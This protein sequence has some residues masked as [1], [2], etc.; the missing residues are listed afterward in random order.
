MH[1]FTYFIA[2]LSIIGAW[3]L[4]ISLTSS[5]FV[6]AVI[7]IVTMGFLIALLMDYE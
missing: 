6:V 2:V 3:L 1:Y 5:E 7:S 4:G